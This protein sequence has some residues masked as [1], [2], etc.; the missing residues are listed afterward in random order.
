[1]KSVRRKIF[2]SFGILALASS[3]I[4]MGLATFLLLRQE[5]RE[6][7]ARI[8]AEEKNLITL[9]VIDFI[10]LAEYREFIDQIAAS[11]PRDELNEVIHIYEPPGKLIYSNQSQHKWKIA[12]EVIVKYV[13]KDYFEIHQADREYLAKIHSYETWDGKILWFEIATLRTSAWTSIKS[14]AS[15]FGLSLLGLLAV[16]LIVSY[17]LGKKITFPIESFAE[18][19]SR[20]DTKGVKTWTSLST[21]HDDTVEMRPIVNSFKMLMDRL[22]QTFVRN[23]YVGRFIAHE[24]Q[25]PLTVIQG[26]VEMSL[27]DPQRAQLE[28]SLKESVLEEV[29][30]ISDVMD[31]VLKVPYGDRNS[32][33]IQIE[34]HDLK[35][36][37]SDVISKISKT[38]HREIIVEF[39]KV[40][41][42]KIYTDQHLFSLLL[43]NLIRNADRHTPQ[44][45]SLTIRS[46]IEDNRV[47]I[48]LVDQGDGLPA[49][50]LN[51]ANAANAFSSELGIGLILTKQ[52]ADLLQHH[53]IFENNSTGKGLCVK[54][55]TP[56]AD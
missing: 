23:E 26:E 35:V 16:S 13:N 10:S 1:M 15:L 18:E 56:L 38:V 50:L 43:S 39:I 51:A 3:L 11:I 48:E 45:Q 46:Y 7:K 41:E 36:L 42:V 47:V 53:V 20:L 40:V 49:A 29:V 31:T 33:P 9:G 37:I 44:H 52:I 34:I 5:E 32:A 6:A 17:W 2:W 4:A 55:L 14:V 12:Q 27:S 28:R 8:R 30:K 21:E 19:I 25:T 54:I 22:Q 24:I